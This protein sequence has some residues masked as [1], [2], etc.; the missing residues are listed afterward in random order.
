MYFHQLCTVYKQA[1]R[2]TMNCFYRS[3]ASE[4]RSRNRTRSSRFRLTHV[5]KVGFDFRL[6]KSAPVFDPVCLQPKKVLLSHSTGERVI[7]LCTSTTDMATGCWFQ[8]PCGHGH[9]MGPVNWTVLPFAEFYAILDQVLGLGSHVLDN[10]TGW[11]CPEP[12]TA[13]ILRVWS[14]A[15]VVGVAVRSN[16][17]R[18][19]AA[20]LTIRCKSS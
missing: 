4:N 6:R 20:D 3:R 11:V 12:P 17:R 8:K 14:G 16:S 9:D 10:I 13:A 2:K 19:S 18:R 1:K 7:P 5:P 15:R